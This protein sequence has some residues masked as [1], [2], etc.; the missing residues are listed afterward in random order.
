MRH[1][2]LDEVQRLRLDRRPFALATVV[3]AEQ[4]ASGTPGARAVV[5]PD[6]HMVG[7]VGGHCAQ[8]TVTRLALAALTDGE[9]RLVVLSPAVSEEATP[10]PGVVQVPMR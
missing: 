6:G 7:W 8:P 3:A 5:L 10:R 4:P 1:D 9:S 2:L